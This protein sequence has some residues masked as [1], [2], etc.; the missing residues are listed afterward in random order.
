MTEVKEPKIKI[1][2]KAFFI[3]LG[4]VGA[5]L[6]VTGI[7]F[8]GIGLSLFTNNN[9]ASPTW[10][11]DSQFGFNLTGVGI[12]F[13]VG[14]MFTLIGTFIMF[15]FANQGKISLFIAKQQVPVI[16]YMAEATAP[17]VEV[18]AEAS[19]KG[20]RKG[21]NLDKQI[22]TIATGIGG[23][24]ADTK[25]KE[26]IRIKCRNCGYLETEDAEFCSKC[27]QKI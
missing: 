1:R 3:I 12:G 25:P 6:L 5:I 26:V 14:G 11:Q 9:F 16:N 7:V 8:M 10:W 4:I 24:G 19:S 27:G 13:I 23:R 21:L 2:G 20:L 15:S 22:E 17:A 18:T